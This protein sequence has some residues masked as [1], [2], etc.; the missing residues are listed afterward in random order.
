MKS[1][2]LTYDG[3]L[4][5][6]GESQIL[7]YLSSLSLNDNKVHII[8]FEKYKSLKDLNIKLDELN[9]L[10]ISWT[11]LRFSESRNPFIK[12]FDLLKCFFVI[13]KTVITFKPDFIHA[14]GH[15]MALLALIFNKI[16][17]IKY[18]FDFRGLWA[19]ERITKGGWNME[20]FWHRVHFRTFKRIEQFSLKH[21]SAIVFLTRKVKD[22][23]IKPSVKDT[24]IFRIIPCASDYDLFN[25]LEN[26]QNILD[27]FKFNISDELIIS[28]L[29]SIGPMYRFDKYVELVFL[30]SQLKINIKD[31]IITKELDLARKIIT[32]KFGN[33]S[34]DSYFFYSAQ[35]SEVPKLVAV[36]D[37]V[38]AFYTNAY[39]MISVSPTKIGEALA[40]GTPVIANQGIG[41]TDKIIQQVNGGIIIP[42]FSEESLRNSIK[43]FSSISQN[44]RKILREKSRSIF[45]LEH[46]ASEYQSIYENLNREK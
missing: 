36:S 31:L 6:L 13:I 27:K 28:Y 10:G 45:G 39:S 29:G 19:D 9:S 37:Y 12:G 11:Y 32:K 7:P 42:D 46:A 20:L 3:M 35:R 26:K 24:R 34:L 23:L 21:S 18:I 4:D 1:I 41:D 16:L 44:E 2:F 5:Q 30:C 14:R 17:R 38:V 15:P 40:C 33:N 43:S 22:E 25:I 8:S